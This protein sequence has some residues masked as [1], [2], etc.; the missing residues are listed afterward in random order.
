MYLILCF[1]QEVVYYTQ[2]G[3]GIWKA[4]LIRLTRNLDNLQSL[5][6]G[7]PDNLSGI[8]CNIKE[9]CPVCV[10][11]TARSCSP[12]GC[13]CVCVLM[14]TYIH[15]YM[16]PLLCTQLW[17]Y[18]SL[19]INLASI[20]V[21]WALLSPDFW[22]LGWTAPGRPWDVNWLSVNFSNVQVLWQQHNF[23]GIRTWHCSSFKA[24]SPCCPPSSALLTP[25]GPILWGLSPFLL[26]INKCEETNKIL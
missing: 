13:V 10:S 17:L 19:G 5:T 15:A 11:L 18:T 9:P 24:Q 16:S 21:A 22:S 26:Q 6:Q 20:T 3:P 12:D 25:T 14:H 2:L 4:W 1:L 7:K 23:L 8:F